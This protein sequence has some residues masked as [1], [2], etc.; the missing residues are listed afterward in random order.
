MKF[1]NCFHLPVLLM[2]FLFSHSCTRES[3]GIE[4]LRTICF[5]TEI[6]PVFQA[7]CA[8]TDCHGAAAREG[9]RLDHYEGIM[10]GVIPGNSGNSRV[11]RAI[12]ARGE[13]HMPPGAI[14]RLEDRMLI[15]IWI[16]Q[17]AEQTICLTPPDSINN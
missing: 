5:D 14:I 13:D 4:D 12:T 1:E 2:C 6:L 3:A 9:L 11:Y 8:T 17:G 15:R 16:D 7:G 10:Q